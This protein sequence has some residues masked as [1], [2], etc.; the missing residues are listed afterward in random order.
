MPIVRL[1]LFVVM[2]LVSLGGSASAVTPEEL[3]ALAKA[4]L[5]DEVLLALIESTGLDRAVGAPQSLALKTAGVSDRVIAAAVRASHQP[6]PP[7]AYESTPVA[8]CDACDANVAVVGG[9]TEVAVV[10]QQVSYQPWI[11]AVPVHGGRRGPQRPYLDGYKGFGRFINDGFVDRT[12][13]KR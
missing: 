13:R 10:E 4:G 12:T 2:G 3:A 1:L 11:W 9:T 5:G 8:P 6:A 7:P